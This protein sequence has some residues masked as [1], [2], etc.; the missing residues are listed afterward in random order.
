MQRAS[1]HDLVRALAP[2]YAHEKGQIPEEVCQLRSCLRKVSASI[3][4]GHLTS[5]ISS[6]T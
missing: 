6:A 1:G 4:E 3:V 2:R 5:R